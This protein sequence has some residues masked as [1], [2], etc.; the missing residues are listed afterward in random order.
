MTA[1]PTQAISIVAR[2]R[3]FTFPSAAAF[4]GTAGAR[5]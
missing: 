2:H 4:A 3:R 1:T 5:F